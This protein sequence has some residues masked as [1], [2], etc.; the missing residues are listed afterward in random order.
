[1]LYGFASSPVTEGAPKYWLALRAR[2]EVTDAAWSG[3]AS[4]ISYVVHPRAITGGCV[5]GESLL[6]WSPKLY[7]HQ[8]PLPKGLRP[9]FLLFW[10]PVL[11]ASTFGKGHIWPRS[12]GLFPCVVL[13]LYV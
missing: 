3:L 6:E 7:M 11:M 12:F 5:G 9:V 2:R 13:C 10:M 8:T 4:G 1:M